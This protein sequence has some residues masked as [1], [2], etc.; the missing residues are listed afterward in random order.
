MMHSPFLTLVLLLAIIYGNVYFYSL[1]T[2]LR[3]DQIR[4]VYFDLAILGNV[5]V[6]GVLFFDVYHHFYYFLTRVLPPL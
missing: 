4:S 3:F 1:R 6:L 2:E 5:S